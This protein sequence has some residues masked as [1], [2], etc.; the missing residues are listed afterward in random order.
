MVDFV[1]D[2]LGGPAGEGFDSGLEFCC[3][4]LH[5]YALVTLTLTRSTEERGIILL[6]DMGLI[7]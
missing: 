7:S 2:Y 4:P 3:L 6:F 5:F 1:L